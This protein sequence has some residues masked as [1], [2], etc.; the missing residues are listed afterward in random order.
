M[1]NFLCQFFFGNVDGY[2]AQEFLLMIVLDHS[3]AP[4]LKSVP[5]TFL[6]GEKKF[7]LIGSWGL[8]RIKTYLKP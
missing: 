1:L 5:V 4:C 6:F 3:H 2:F 7:M 8:T